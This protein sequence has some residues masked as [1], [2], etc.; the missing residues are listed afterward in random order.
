MASQLR[1]PIKRGE[2]VQTSD[3]DFNKLGGDQFV[4]VN[5]QLTTLGTFTNYKSGTIAFAYDKADPTEVYLTNKGTF[6]SP[7]DI[8]LFGSAVNDGQMHISGQLEI[9]TKN[10]TFTNSNNATLK[11]TSTEFLLDLSEVT[12]FGTISTA[13]Q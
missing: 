9:Y 1:N 6:N 3:G 8:L 12:N 4:K 10:T 13:K 2:Q 11:Y 7:G 5:G